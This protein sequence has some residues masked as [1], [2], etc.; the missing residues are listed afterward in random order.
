MVLLGVIAADTQ[1][2]APAVRSPR[3]SGPAH[4]HT[5]WA[6]ALFTT[7]PLVTQTCHM[8][9]AGTAAPDWDLQGFPMF[10]QVW[11]LL[12]FSR[13]RLA[14]MGWNFFLWLDLS[15][16]P[17]HV[18]SL[19]KEKRPPHRELAHCWVVLESCLVGRGPLASSSLVS[20]A[21]GAGAAAGAAGGARGEWLGGGGICALAGALASRASSAFLFKPFPHLDVL[22]GLASRRGLEMGLVTDDHRV[23]QFRG[24]ST[25]ILCSLYTVDFKRCSGLNC[26]PSLDP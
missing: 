17:G 6:A 22:F 18:R 20:R 3:S 24:G 23:W 14:L 9:G 11:P 19:G 25:F 7:T 12:R 5:H 16:P 1:R 4:T 2:G 15:L 21:V 13:L 10:V 26:L 8:G